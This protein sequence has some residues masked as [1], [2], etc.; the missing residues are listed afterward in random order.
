MA[1]FKSPRKT[2]KPQN[3]KKV[4][5][6]G[7]TIGRV[8]K[9]GMKSTE[10]GGLAYRA[11]RLAKRVANA[12]N[13]EYKISDA[14]NVA[15]AVDY[16]GGVVSLPSNISQGIT[17]STRIGD[18]IKIQNLTL[19]YIGVRNTADSIL[20]VMVLFDPQN[21]IAA[22]TDVLQSTGSALSVISPKN[23]DKRFQ[24]NVLYDRTMTLTTADHPYV[25][26]D[27]V[28]PID[29]HCQYNAATTTVNTG[30]IKLLTISNVSGVNL[31]TFTYYARLSYTDD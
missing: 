17:D 25:V 31:P 3:K 22:V 20:R 10:K 6:W 19:R 28:I 29:K 27:I 21:K 2:K 5:G 1:K 7:G 14:S 23:Y 12:V 15:G 16:T 11:F 9:V 8:M 30:D 13:V 18:S 26:E 4:P 24:N